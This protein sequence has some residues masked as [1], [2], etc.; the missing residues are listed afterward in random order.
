MHIKFNV[1]SHV[2]VKAETDLICEFLAFIRDFLL[3]LC[4]KMIPFLYWIMS[5]A[6][7]IVGG[8]RSK[9][10]SQDK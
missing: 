6:V 5:V 8:S 1:Y 7:G 9:N 4:D 10:Q 3:H 2:W